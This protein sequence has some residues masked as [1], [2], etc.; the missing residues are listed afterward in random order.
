MDVIP[1]LSIGYAVFCNTNL[2]SA[3]LTRNLLSQ[4]L[5][6]ICHEGWQIFQLVVCYSTEKSL[7]GHILKNS[8]STTYKMR[9]I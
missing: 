4:L 5:Q 8:E 1:D 2:S 9:S 3:H 7:A 6:S